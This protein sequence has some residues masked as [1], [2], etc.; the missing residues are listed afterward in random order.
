MVYVLPD[1][2]L[3]HSHQWQ[4]AQDRVEWQRA[5]GEPDAQRQMMA[6]AMLCANPLTPEQM[7]QDNLTVHDVPPREGY[8]A[9]SA[10][11]I[12]DIFGGGLPDPHLHDAPPTGFGGTNGE[13]SGT[14]Y[15]SMPWH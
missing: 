8:P 10:P 11:T 5:F 7:I 9:G 2:A 14:D 6:Q 15:P 12:D 1:A 3:D 4:N 13:Y